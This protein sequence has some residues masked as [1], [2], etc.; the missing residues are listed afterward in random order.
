MVKYFDSRQCIRS[1]IPERHGSIGDASWYTRSLRNHSQQLKLF[2]L[3]WA[4]LDVWAELRTGM[5]GVGK[6]PREIRIHIPVFMT[7]PMLCTKTELVLLAISTPKPTTTE[8]VA[9]LL[10]TPVGVCCWY[11]QAEPKR[12]GVPLL[13]H[14]EVH[15]Y[16]FKG[17]LLACPQSWKFGVGC[18]FFFGTR[19][20]RNQRATSLLSCFFLV[21]GRLGL[22]PQ[23]NLV[24]SGNKDH[25]HAMG[26]RGYPFTSDDVKPAQ[27]QTQS[28]H[29]VGLDMP[30]WVQNRFRGIL[31]IDKS[32]VESLL[33]T[34][35]GHLSPLLDREW[36]KWRGP[37]RCNMAPDRESVLRAT[38]TPFGICQ[39]HSPQ[40]TQTIKNGL[41]K[42]NTGSNMITESAG[43]LWSSCLPGTCPERSRSSL[44][45]SL[46]VWYGGLVCLEVRGLLGIWL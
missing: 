33:H 31:S 15:P 11:D 10:R 6:R 36:H 42:A 13:E 16:Q 9:T 45:G 14:K 44:L 20:P 21:A 28:G 4:S 30:V 34:C 19:L 40:G 35:T 23:C 37:R 29:Q 46:F 43:E 26:H 7:M 32:R 38:A 22:L 3:N 1:Q 25:V 18:L 17:G 5:D 2:K 27:S 39:W 8:A 24:Q 41:Q 12:S